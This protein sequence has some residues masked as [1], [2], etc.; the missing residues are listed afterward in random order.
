VAGDTRRRA[1]QCWKCLLI[2][3][4]DERRQS[5]R[6]VRRAHAAV[7]ERREKVIERFELED[8]QDFRLVF[9]ERKV[10]PP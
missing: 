3:L 6:N 7:A 10:Q 5:C 1:F 9:A 4:V 2:V 8:P